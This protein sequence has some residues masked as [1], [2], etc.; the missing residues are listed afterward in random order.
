MANYE[1][2]K[3]AIQQVVKT[4]G[5]N[6]IT[7]ALLQQSL[8]AMINSLGS[9][10]QFAGIATPATNPGTP[11]AKMFYI[12][13]GKG[14]YTNF[15]G[16]NVN[17]DEVVFLMFEKSWTKLKS[18][19]A[20]NDDIREL[21]SNDIKKL[22][23]DVFKDAGGNYEPF[24]EWELGFINLG[25][26]I[27]A[28]ASY[29]YSKSAYPLKKGDIVTVE[30]SG[31]GFTAIAE[32]KD[33]QYKPL[34]QVI[35]GSISDVLTWKYQVTEDADI[36]FCVKKLAKWSVS[37]YRDVKPKDYT[38]ATSHVGNI[39]IIAAKEH[40]YTD[41][42]LPVI[43]WY[44][45]CD[46]TSHKFYYSKDLTTKKFLFLFPDSQKYSYG[47]MP[48]GDIIAV[49]LAESL[50]LTKSDS[51][52]VNPYVMKANENWGV[53]HEVDFGE[54]VVKPC[55]WLENCGFLAMPNGDTMFVEYTRVSVETANVW[56]ITG[57]VLNA[58]NWVIKKTFQ[59]SGEPD[60]G[61]KH[62]HNVNNDPYN[63]YIYVTTGD[64][65]ASAI[66]VSKD[67]GENF[68]AIF[69]NDEGR[70]RT[71]AMTF[72]QDYICY[73]NDSNRH[74]FIKAPRRED[75]VM[76]IDKA[77]V[78]TLP[79]IANRNVASYGQAYIRE[80]N[81]VLVLDRQDGVPSGTPAEFPLYVVDLETLTY[82][83]V[84]MLKGVSINCGFRTVYTEWYPKDGLIHFG[85]GT[86]LSTINRNKVCG[87]GVN[88]K[89]NGTQ[90]VNNLTVKVGKD[91]DK[92]NLR[93]GT[94]FI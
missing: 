8:L 92:Y 23:K 64:Y 61:L 52:R 72:T 13:N 31:N 57:D 19:I 71:L 18:G 28:S 89:W 74:K 80:Y 21:I 39:S 33:G 35:N 67:L 63:G 24:L 81:A 46:L 5:N 22:R 65:E 17:E 38:N 47:I 88:T 53:I 75:G 94:L 32:F 43:E 84:Y 3:T 78:I 51:N 93:F 30:T 27:Q 55:G 68:E 60:A 85:F 62:L 16:L 6:E 29:Q 59:L 12:A 15:G 25:G 54:R 86:T 1:T 77:E 34:F 20:L 44:L 76:D 36:V 45:L 83:E 73:A 7:G 9:G 4:N 69:E 10:Y 41:G 2:L 91:G 14:I 26:Q 50:P 87:N 48:N 90:T 58:D 66:Y 37:I 79:I 49:R 40:H 56:K 42:T 11:D 70:C 82:S